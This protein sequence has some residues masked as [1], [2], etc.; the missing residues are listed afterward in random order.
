MTFHSDPEIQPA[1]ASEDGGKTYRLSPVSE[2]VGAL[3]EADLLRERLEALRPLPEKAHLW[4]ALQLK[5]RMEWTYHSNAI[6][7]STLTL[8]ETIFFL[9]HGLTVE[10]KPFKDFLDARNH[11]EAIEFLFS[12][13]KEGLPISE[14]FLRQVNALLLTGVTHTDAIDQFGARTRKPATPGEYKKLPNTVL[15][16]DGT[17]YEY[18]HPFRVR[19][20][21]E[22]LVAWINGEGQSLHPVIQ[23]AVAHYNFVRIHPFDD[24]NGRGARIL[25]NLILLKRGF[26]TV[27]IRQE[28]RF[29]YITSLKKADEGNLNP[30]A[31]FVAE[32]LRETLS[33]MVETLDKPE[34]AS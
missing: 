23:A 3:A 25:M 33:L 13:I 30:F 29:E 15:Q 32:S 22:R 24:G 31:L 4:E 9:Q 17:I 1:S 2:L 21:M 10:G 16:P 28:R 5:L 7:G 11:Q 6:E 27:V 18:V 19:E 20:E 12:E 26:P 8:G 14:S 34:S